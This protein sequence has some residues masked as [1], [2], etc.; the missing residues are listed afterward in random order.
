VRSPVKQG[1]SSA[2][3]YESVPENEYIVENFYKS[4]RRTPVPIL[5]NEQ[6]N[7]KREKNSAK[8]PVMNGTHYICP[9]REQDAKIFIMKQIK[10]L[11]A[12]VVLAL[13]AQSWRIFQKVRCPSG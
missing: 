2:S 10:L 13:A 7:E 3:R 12:L 5:K 1:R 4:T 8:T 11:I 6:N 9:F